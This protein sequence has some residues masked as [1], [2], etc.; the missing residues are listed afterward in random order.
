M[1]TVALLA[2]LAATSVAQAETIAQYLATPATAPE[3]VEDLGAGDPW[4]I[5][6]GMHD[7]H[8]SLRW[9][10]L[11]LPDTDP[12]YTL[13][14]HVCVERAAHPDML[15]VW[16]RE[17]GL[18]VGM[19]AP[20]GCNF[21]AG[22]FIDL[23]IDGASIGG[24]QAT[25]ERLTW[26]AATGYRLTWQIPGATVALT[27][28]GADG[29]DHLTLHGAVQSEEIINTVEVRLRCF[30]SSFTE[31]RERFVATAGREL[32]AGARVVL[33]PDECWALFA[34]RHF[35]EATLPAQSRG[36]CALLFEPMQMSRAMLDV[37]ACQ[38]EAQ[39]ELMPGQT[40][41]DLAL[42]EF[43]DLANA[44]ALAA[45]RQVTADLEPAGAQQ[46][47]VAAPPRVLVSDGRP[48]AR[49]RRREAARPAAAVALR[50]RP[51]RRGAGRGMVRDRLR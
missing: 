22:G 21:Y 12:Q 5:E 43:P 17:G 28:V 33:P 14:Y 23:L 29:D 49:A 34:D 48:A 25:I 16:P 11:A 36:P 41:F 18:G 37:G 31:P 15:E 2:A 19:I 42:W 20:T 3:R 38:I 9:P 46:Q 51:R 30:P 4:V 6:G 44:A 7:G 45:M 24:N 39:F 1:R 35:D 27:F 26:P 32:E 40:S 47:M 10:A 8:A 13:T 50:A